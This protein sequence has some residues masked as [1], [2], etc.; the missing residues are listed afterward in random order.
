MAINI[1]IRQTSKKY[2]FITDNARV[3]GNSSLENES[4]GAANFGEK[5]LGNHT[6]LKSIFNHPNSIINGG[7]GSEDK[8]MIIAPAFLQGRNDLSGKSLGDEIAAALE[9]IER[10]ISERETTLA[11]QTPPGDRDADTVLQK[12]LQ[13][14]STLSGIINNETSD[15]AALSALL[16]SSE[17]EYNPDFPLSN[18]NF[19]Y[20]AITTETSRAKDLHSRTTAAPRSP[21]VNFPSLNSSL[22][23]NE[24]TA[25]ANTDIQGLDGQGGFG[26]STSSNFSTSTIITAII[27]RYI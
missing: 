18:V 7:N 23:N 25:N 8:D 9:I 16:V 5:G 15:P 2:G 22:N 19:G 20:G 14:E 4:Y 24:A 11:A 26:S 1:P 17:F 13:D 21:N 27:N 10:K 6:S 3:H 12:L